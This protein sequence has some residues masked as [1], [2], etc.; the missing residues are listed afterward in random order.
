MNRIFEVV[1]QYPFTCLWLIV[2]AVSIT[3]MVLESNKKRKDRD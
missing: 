2:I 1:G 3:S